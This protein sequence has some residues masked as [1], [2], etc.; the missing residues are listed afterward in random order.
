[1]VVTDSLTPLF[2]PSSIAVYGASK[3]DDRRLGNQLLRNVLAGGASSV[4][5][6]HPQG[7]ELEGLTAVPSVGRAVDLALVSV[8]AAR[9]VAAVRD[10]AQA[11]ARSVVVLSSG[12]GEAGP[13]GAA[14]QDELVAM[15]RAS[16]TR[17]V[18]P[19]CMGVLSHRGGDDWLDGSYF[20]D[21]PHRPGGVS[22]VTQSGAFGGIFLS[23]VRQRHAGMARF[24]S[25]GNAADVTVSDA[26]E[27]LGAD[28]RTTTIGLF[29][30]SL[31][32]GHRFVEVARKVSAAKPIVAIKAGRSRSG[33]RAAASHT[34][35]IAGA[36]GPVRAAFLRAGIH[37]EIDS[38]AFFDRLFATSTL[39]GRI[40]DNVA[41]ITVSGGPGVL[42]ADAVE[43][44]GGQLP[45]LDAATQATIRALVPDFAPTTNPVD[46][47]PQCLPERMDEAVR[48]VFRAADVDG[49]VLIDCGLDVAALGH[50]VT[51]GARETGKPVTAYVLDTPDLAEALIAGD[52]P[53][54]PSVERAVGAL[55]AGGRSTTGADV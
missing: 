17:L 28:D 31:A 34:G 6:V 35:S 3:R 22:F 29:V 41:I 49:V 33:A 18:G 55:L 5:A 47:T 14:I 40:V 9:A 39:S 45:E 30:E 36:Y 46:L 53:L 54:F 20:W 4:V 1:M 8:P 23:E 24:L 26:L 2:E 32:D 52:V 44:L 11:G 37:A 38:Q 48:A 12:F 16:G 27:W 42:A 7:G 15:T 51:A 50:A 19:N 13:K 43:A 21:V 10:A 25:L